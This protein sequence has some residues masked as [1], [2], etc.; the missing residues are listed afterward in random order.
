MAITFSG[1]ATGLDTDKIVKDIMALERAP[2]DRIEARKTSAKQRLDAYGQFKDK[3]DALKT[4]VGNMSLTSQLRSTKATISG[5]ASFSA[6]STSGMTGSYNVSVAQLSQVQKTIS[7]GFSSNTDSLLGTGPI[8]VNGTTITITSENNSLAGLAQAVNAQ[9]NTTGVRASIINSGTGSKPY[10]LVFTGKDSS[11]VFKVESA[12]VGFSEQIVI[13]NEH[14]AQKAQKAVAYIDGIAVVSDTNTISTAISGV[15]LTLNSVDTMTDAGTE[16]TV[17]ETVGGV[18]VTKTIDFWE[19]ADP[20]TFASKKMDVTADTG[21]LKEKVTT[22]V[23]AYNEAMEW[24]LSGYIEFGGTSTVPE[25]AEGSDEEAILGSVLRG[26]ATI[27]SLKRQMQ[28]VLTG[29]INN[30]GGFK[31]LS[32]IGITSRLDGTLNQNNSKLDKALADNYDNTIYLLSG[33]DTT[34][35]V[36]KNFN[37]LLL[38]VTST[39]NGMYALQKKNY[40]D[41]IGR[42]DYQIDQM[43]LRLSKREQSFKAQFSAMET[44]VSSLN[45]QGD[46]LTQQMNAIFGNNK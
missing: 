26:D 8:T 15:T 42:F 11:T 6:T 46:F 7:N 31:I 14:P 4:A 24:I 20:P 19:W 3:L 2:L 38:K 10:H 12:L 33:D 27:N 43:E 35:G 30:S 18:T 28:N 13:D 1:L 25:V 40:E 29:A 39:S 45:A 36:M 5:E 16:E 34:D 23:S 44:L 17:D 22:F 32:E 41:S 37:A 9:A 21:A